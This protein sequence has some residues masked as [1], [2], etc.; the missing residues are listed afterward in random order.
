MKNIKFTLLALMIVFLV[1]CSNNTSVEEIDSNSDTIVISE[2]MYVTWIN[3]IYVNYQDYIGK[4]IKLEGMYTNYYSMQD[5][6]TYNMVY[7]VG[8]GC[9]GNDG[10]MAGFKFECAGELPKENDWI[11]V[12]GVLDTYEAYEINN[13]I[14][15]D[16][17]VKVKEERGIETVG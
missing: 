17:K 3:E 5:D 11:E 6:E 16:A 7:R 14:L 9:C 15:K 1:G 12:E 4:K 8:P 13:L 10:N 2:D